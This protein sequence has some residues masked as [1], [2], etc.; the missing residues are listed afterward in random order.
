MP[1]S[2]RPEAR[3]RLHGRVE[4][5]ARRAERA[6]AGADQVRDAVERVSAEAAVVRPVD[7]EGQR[8]LTRR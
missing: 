7:D 1:A 4:V 8:A 5:V 2:W 6:A 3:Q